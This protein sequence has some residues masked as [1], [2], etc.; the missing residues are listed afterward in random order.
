MAAEIYHSV[1]DH[2]TN[3]MEVKAIFNISSIKKRLMERRSFCGRLF[4]DSQDMGKTVR[5]VCK[6]I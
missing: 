5:R 4:P 3:D 1:F 2:A 6:K